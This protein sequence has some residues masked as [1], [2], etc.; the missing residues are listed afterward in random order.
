MA[1]T[2]IVIIGFVLLLYLAA[3]SW[4]GPGGKRQRQADLSCTARPL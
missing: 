4:T 2:A 3:S 1:S